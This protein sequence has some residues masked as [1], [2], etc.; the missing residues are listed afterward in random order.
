MLLELEFHL[1]D[2]M[3]NPI[4]LQNTRIKL[5]LYFFGATKILQ[6]LALNLLNLEEN[7]IYDRYLL[8]LKMMMMS[9]QMMI[10]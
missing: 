10:D 1:I 7:Q 9:M 2:P 8:M 5:N 3:N 6:I 4:Y